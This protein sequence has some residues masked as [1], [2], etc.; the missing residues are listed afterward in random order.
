MDA[1]K[2]HFFRQVG[3]VLLLILI[4]GAVQGQDGA[5]LFTLPDDLKVITPF[6]IRALEPVVTL[7]KGRLLDIGTLDNDRI[8]AALSSNGIWLYD[9]GD[10]SVA[11]TRVDFTVNPFVEGAPGPTPDGTPPLDAAFEGTTVRF[12]WEDQLWT[13]DVMS[14]DQQTEP[15]PEDIEENESDVTVSP[16]GR[17]EVTMKRDP[18]TFRMTQTLSSTETDTTHNLSEAGCGGLSMRP[19]FTFSKDSTRVFSATNGRDSAITA[20]D[21]ET[22]A[23][24]GATGG[25]EPSLYDAAISGDGR[26][27]ATVGGAQ[28]IATMALCPDGRNP[29]AGIYLYNLESGTL[30]RVSAPKMLTPYHV[31]LSDDGSILAVI[32]SGYFDEEKFSASN[33][34]DTLFVWENGTP[35]GYADVYKPLPPEELTD[36]NPGPNPGSFL[37][38]A[39]SADGKYLAIFGI[40]AVHVWDLEAFRAGEQQYTVLDVRYTSDEVFPNAWDIIR[41]HW[42]NRLVAFDEHMLMYADVDVVRLWDADEQQEVGV[43]ENNTFV[44]EIIFDAEN[45]LL[46][47]QAIDLVEQLIAQNAAS[48]QEMPPETVEKLRE[49][50]GNSVTTVWQLGETPTIFRELPIIPANQAA[51]HPNGSLLAAQSLSDGATFIMPLT[52]L[53]IFSI[54]APIRP[55]PIA[56]SPD[57]TLIVL[58]SYTNGLQLW[59]VTE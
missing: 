59:G 11:P 15:A 30:T 7:D 16:D 10:L 46:Y 28:N 4:G 56:F 34:Y 13:I 45:K 44:R 21:V 53:P 43:L 9:A 6:N 51:V 29:G 58:V 20:W 14:G 25:F 35:V 52:G 24:L 38:I 2:K 39:L 54:D 1:F 57:G 3:L 55:L 40:R 33:I 12:V 5:P 26:L 47:V 37:D 27:L 42:G 49:A 41:Q 36:G 50:Y 18:E 48:G 8:L 32:A 31:A 22:G 19:A 17:W 23:F